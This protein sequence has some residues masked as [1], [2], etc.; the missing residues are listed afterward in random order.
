MSGPPGSPL[1]Q[2]HFHRMGTNNL[3]TRLMLDLKY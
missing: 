2:V 1:D 3:N